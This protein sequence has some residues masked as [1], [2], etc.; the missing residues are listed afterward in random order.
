MQRRCFIDEGS[1]ARTTDSKGLLFLR[2]SVPLLCALSRRALPRG[3]V[4]R[5][6]EVA[7]VVRRLGVAPV[8][9]WR[10]CLSCVSHGVY[11]F[12]MSTHVCVHCRANGSRRKRVS[13]R[14][15]GLAHEWHESVAALIRKQ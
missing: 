7:H 13:C 10:S 2:I 11:V 15:L 1:A 14:I 3:H 5:A 4:R 12:C 8:A 9:L 6:S